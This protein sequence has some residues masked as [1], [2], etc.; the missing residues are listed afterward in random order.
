MTCL[1]TCN[2]CICIFSFLVITE[3]LDPLEILVQDQTKDSLT[4]QWGG[5]PDVQNPEYIVTYKKVGTT[6]APTQLTFTN[7]LMGQLTGLEAG[8][9]YEI[10]VTYL[11][12]ESPNT[13]V[14]F[15]S[16]SFENL[17]FF[18]WVM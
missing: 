15:A 2:K 10:K 14:F 7:M 13:G 4:I 16:K 8:A 12:L 9:G 11:N 5:I 1:E 18:L 17:F 3:A 6:N